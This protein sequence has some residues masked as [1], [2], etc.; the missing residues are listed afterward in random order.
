MSTNNTWT[1]LGLG[2]V[3]G[4]GCVL[5]TQQWQCRSKQK[6]VDAIKTLVTKTKTEERKVLTMEQF[7]RIESFFGGDG[8]SAIQESFVIVV[9]LGG[10]GSHAANMLARSGVKKIRLIDFDNVTL[11]SLNRHA[12][13]TRED[14]GH[15]K[16]EATKRHLLQTVPDCE[17]EVC[18]VMFNEEAAEVLLSGIYLLPFLYNQSQK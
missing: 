4:A 1:N 15:S 5:A 10:V 11:S 14:V 17:I 8:F 12:V 13:A 6:P 9:G 16:V 3:L 2:A 7:S 18:P